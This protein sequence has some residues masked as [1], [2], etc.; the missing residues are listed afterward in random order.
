MKTPPV[1]I[2]LLLSVISLAH[3]EEVVVRAVELTAFGTFADYGKKFER[4]YSQSGPGTESLEYVR[5][6]DITTQIPGKLGTSFGIQ[7]IIHS[8]PKGQPF[9]VTGV[10]V[11]PGDGLVTPEGY[12]YQSSQ[13]SIEIKI[14]EKSFYGFGFDHPWEIIPGDWKFQIRRGDAIL[15]QKILTVLSPDPTFLENPISETGS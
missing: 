13:E 7:Y 5:F 12:V 3:A 10:I 4:G 1:V 2:A 11:Y 15:A 8:S 6:A 14:G 9:R